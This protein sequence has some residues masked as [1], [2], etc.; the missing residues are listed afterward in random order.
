MGCGASSNMP[1]PST[2]YDKKPKT[3]DELQGK[4]KYIGD[5]GCVVCTCD[6]A[7]TASGLFIV[8]VSENGSTVFVATTAKNE[9]IFVSELTDEQFTALRDA[10]GITMTFSAIYKSIATEVTKSKVKISLLDSACNATLQVSSIKDAKTIVP[11]TVTLALLSAPIQ[12]ARAK[13]L[14]IPLSMMVQKKRLNTEDKEKEIKVSRLQMQGTIW[15][16]SILASRDTTERIRKVIVPLRELAAQR[17]KATTEVV[18]K[19]EQIERRIKRMQQK[20]PSSTKLLDLVYETGGAQFFQHLPDAE[21]HVPAP[22]SVEADEV[23]PRWIRSALPN[24]SGESLARLS[25][26]PGDPDLAKL[27]SSSPS[28]Q[29]A[30]QAMRVLERL[31]EWDMSVFDLEKATNN[32]ALYFTTYAILYKLNLVSHFNIDDRI[33]RNFL[34]A[35]QAGYHPNPYHNATHAADVCQV[36]YFIMTKGGIVQKL[37]LGKEEL[38]AGVLAGAIHDYDHPGFNNNFHTRTNAYLSTLY[39]DRSILENHHCACITEIL[40]LPQYNFLSQLTDDQ[41]RTI[42]D[43]MLEMVLATDMGNHAK[44]FSSFRRRIAEGPAWHEKR[45]DI[46]LALS[47]SIKMADVSNC[48]RPQ[49]LYLE[50][51]K[52]IATEFYTQGDAEDRRML[53]ISPF[54]DRRKD[55]TDFPKGQISFMN[56]VVVPMFEAIAEFLPPVEVALHCCTENKDYW[57]NLE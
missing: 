41:R 54:M 18:T 24:C 52:N 39:N 50:W 5:L 32:Q 7:K 2:K 38:L 36:N 20:N 19:A 56:Y 14:L 51:A 49:R 30:E 16:A 43:T 34:S 35:L 9:R 26:A 42:R 45:D 31:D 3:S 11:L 53:S 15:Q 13:Y 27:I 29:M 12:Q 40:R 17:S 48:G 25:R 28:G 8:F 4:T 33:L 22:R 10:Q 46:Y 57:Q 21:E 55:K 1:P 37:Q 47:M 6:E 23:L 44:I